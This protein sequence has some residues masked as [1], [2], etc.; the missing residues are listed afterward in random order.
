MTNL[1]LLFFLKF[2]YKEI[3]VG[4]N[5]FEVQTQNYSMNAIQKNNIKVSVSIFKDKNNSTQK[6]E[7]QQNKTQMKNQEKKLIEKVHEFEIQE[8]D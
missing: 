2:K 5:V 1:K 8:K 4:R 6:H 7:S 3:N